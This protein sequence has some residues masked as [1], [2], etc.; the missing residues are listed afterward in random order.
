MKNGRQ[1]KWFP[2][3]QHF[4]PCGDLKHL[5]Q[6][7]NVKPADVDEAQRRMKL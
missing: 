2:S 6:E 1:K 7:W 5:Y 3:N 4:I